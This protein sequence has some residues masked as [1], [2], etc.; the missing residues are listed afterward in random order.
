MLNS[1]PFSGSFSQAAYTV[2]FFLPLLAYQG[3]AGEF[4][5]M[6]TTYGDLDESI[7][8]VSY[9]NAIQFR[10][11]HLFPNS[12]FSVVCDE[13]VHVWIPPLLFPSTLAANK[14]RPTHQLHLHEGHH[15]KTLHATVQLFFHPWTCSDLSTQ[16]N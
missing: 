15:K 3:T 8:D 14:Q 1:I 4:D 5:L 7:A 13:S 12:I 9:I 6:V 16:R 2:A 10:L 11:M